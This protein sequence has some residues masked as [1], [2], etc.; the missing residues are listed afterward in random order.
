[1][2]EAR[3]EAYHDIAQKI[4]DLL[5]QN[6]A[7]PSDSLRRGSYPQHS[8]STP[9]RLN[10]GESGFGRGSPRNWTTG[11]PSI[12]SRGTGE[13]SDDEHGF[14]ETLYAQQELR[15][16]VYDLEG[17][18]SHLIDYPW[19]EFGVEILRDVV[20]N[21]DFLRQASLLPLQTG[22]VEDRSHLSGFQVWDVASDGA[23]L[24]VDYA[25]SETSRAIAIWN[26][27]K[28]INPP[29]RQRKAVGRITIMRELT[30]ILFGALHYVLND[31]FDMDEIFQ[32]LVTADST[33]SHVHRAF[34]LDSRR[35]CSKIFAFEYFTIIGEDC[36]PLH[37]QLS[38]KEIDN[39]PRHIRI[40][41]C[42]AV[43][44]LAM[45][46]DPVRKVRNPSRRAKNQNDYGNIY[47]PFSSWHLLNLQCFP[48]LKSSTDVHDTAKHY[49]NGPE[50]F[51]ITLLGE[52][53]DA[54]RRFEDINRAITKLITP[55]SS[56]MFDARIRDDL[57]FE[58]QHFTYV[59]RYFWAYQT[60]G[61]M[62]ESIR[63]IVDAFEHDFPEELFD[64]KAKLLWPLDDENSARNAF[65]KKRL[66]TLRHK[67]D[68]QMRSFR[69]L[70]Q[71]NEDRRTEI[72]GLREELYVGTSIHESRKSVEMTETTVQQGHNVKLLTLVSI[73]FLPS[74]FVTSVFGMTNMPTQES[75]WLFGVVMA[76]ICVPFF[77]LIGSL[78][79]N[80][81]MNFWLSKG[82]AISRNFLKLF[83]FFGRPFRKTSDVADDKSEDE[84]Q[85]AEERPKPPPASRTHRGSIMPM[86]R[87][88]NR[89]L[90]E[91]DHSD[92]GD[93][94]VS[95]TQK[96][97]SSKL[98]QMFK[99]ERQKRTNSSYEV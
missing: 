32:L 86:P 73:F 62:N 91:S 84:K 56:F 4:H 36:L 72:R 41:R 66:A 76:A 48:D 52:F 99:G 92:E 14:D 21:P 87:R 1:R 68:A 49:V 89:Q 74:Q 35:Q 33:S 42:N 43:I 5:S 29:L 10:Q 59:R 7:G 13:E 95:R 63:A 93:A 81:G 85:D 30:P 23:P 37:W 16:E 75:Y 94:G 65:Y 12:L 97:P 98:A 51:L 53:R 71:G 55:P 18:R 44:A 61:I 15:S 79:T 47:D 82:T 90:S 9:A 20:H 28:E 64:G 50:A 88:S 19:N 8:G 31:T 17:L 96:R 34:E 57:L 24:A 54:Q 80:R 58:D 22:P 39:N 78:N 45:T 3:K 38:D 25:D 70:I 77:I 40:T 11:S 60:L 69:A 83:S 46:S 67:F 6:I 2:F 27:I 26:T